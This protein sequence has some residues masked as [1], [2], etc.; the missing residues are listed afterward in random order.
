[1]LLSDSYRVICVPCWFEIKKEIHAQK[2]LELCNSIEFDHTGI[3]LRADGIYTIVGLF[4][5]LELS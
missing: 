2:L 5:Q 4:L 1:M 3:L